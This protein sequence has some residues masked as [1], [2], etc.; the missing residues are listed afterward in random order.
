MKTAFRYTVN[1]SCSET[2]CYSSLSNKLKCRQCM[3]KLV[4]VFFVDDLS[5]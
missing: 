5:I 3:E 4:I 2:M 1:K